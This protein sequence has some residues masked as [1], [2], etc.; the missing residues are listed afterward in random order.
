MKPVK[1]SELKPGDRIAIS[2]TCGLIVVLA[3]S[4]IEQM[5]YGLLEIQTGD[6]ALQ[7]ICKDEYILADR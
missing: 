3:V 5:P 6:T 1:A 2:R 7:I 4:R